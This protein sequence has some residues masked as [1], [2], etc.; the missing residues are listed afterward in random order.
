MPFSSTEGVEMDFSVLGPMEVTAGSSDVTPTA[1]KLRQVLAI[2]LLRRN[3]LVQTGEFIDELWGQHPPRS[4]MSTLQTYVYKLRRQLFERPGDDDERLT[5]KPSGYILRIGSNDL[6]LGRFEA[7]AEEGY[8]ALESGEPQRAAMLLSS[9]LS[10]WRGPALADVVTGDLLGAYATRL[11]ESRMRALEQRMEA[12]LRLSRHRWVIGELRML[13]TTYPLHEGF[14]AKL[15]LAMYRSGRRYEALNVY[16]RLREVLIEELGLE[17]SPELA[18]LHQ[19]LLSSDPSLDSTGQQPRREAAAV[20]G[21]RTAVRTPAY[22]LPA[23]IDD[24][25]GRMEELARAERWLLGGDAGR[26]SG[27]VV[28]IS[29]MPGAGKSAL[30]VRLAHLLRA[31]F[32]DGALFV[33]LGDGDD[34]PRRPDE[35]LGAVLA[36]IGIAPLQIPDGADE[37]GRMFSRWCAERRVLL[38][39]DD[40]V[41]VGQLEAFLPPGRGCAI[42]VTSRPPL[43]LGGHVVSLDPLTPEDS[44]RVLESAVGDE[45]VAQDRAAAH[46]LVRECG[47]LPLALRA[48]GARLAASP[49]LSLERLGFQ[50]AN[51]AAP[52]NLLRFGPIDVRTRYHSSYNRLSDRDRH[53]LR[54]VSLFRQDSF[55]AADVAPLLGLPVDGAER[56]LARLAEHHLL[57]PA[58]GQPNGVVHYQIHE[59]TRRYARE[60]LEDTLDADD[61][62]AAETLDEPPNVDRLDWSHIPDVA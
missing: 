56:L 49:G 42:I 38:V 48:V 46:R 9:A 47:G 16:R 58:S 15:M 3:G 37:R 27:G 17:P 59:L 22:G 33:G 62:R 20:S 1:P 2:L 52:L 60:R 23:D 35:V 36:D 51:H 53:A 45:R 34:G 10:L 7:R 39:L 40:A 21:P 50:L 57:R 43:A 12:D 44:L 8:L 29:G 11:E 54:L 41:S 31:H 24:F 18:R 30:G 5:T 14:H 19:A 13:T 4:A 26:P 55:T 28:S 32:P 25:A 6:D 61:A